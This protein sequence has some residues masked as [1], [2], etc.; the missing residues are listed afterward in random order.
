MSSSTQDAAAV[1]G[2]EDSRLEARHLQKAYGSRKAVKDV[3]LVVR[4]GEVVGLL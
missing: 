3:S 1:A 4:K 2:L